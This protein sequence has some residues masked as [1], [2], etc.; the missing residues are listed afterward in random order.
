MRAARAAR[1]PI[2]PGSPVQPDGSGFQFMHR[3]PLLI[4][5]LSLAV[6]A[7][8]RA[9]A[10]S[11]PGEEARLRVG[12]LGVTP[13]ISLRNIGFDTNIFNASGEPE[14]DFTTTLGTGADSWLRVGRLYLSGKTSVDWVYFQKNSSQR[15]VN[16]SQEGRVAL[17]L[18]RLVPRAGGGIVNSRQRPNDEFDLRIHQR[19]TSMF[20]GV[21]V[22]IGVKGALDLEYKQQDFDY[23][24]GKFGDALVATA[25]NRESTAVTAAGSLELTPLTALTVRA[26]RRLD[27]FE[28][29]PSRNSNSYRVMPGVEFQPSAV[30]SGSAFVGYRK[31]ETL[32]ADTPDFSGVVAQVR[33][34][35][36]ALDMFRVIG[37]V[38]RD[39]EYSLDLEESF[40]VSTAAGVEVTQALG[41][42]W[43][44]VGRVRRHALAYR[45]TTG[46]G[47]RVDRAWQTGVGFG[48]R[49]GEQLRVGLDV[50]YVRRDSALPSRAFDGFRVGG[51]VT[52]GY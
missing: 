18:L 9:Q 32:S 39:V 8:A 38:V 27:R 2:L 20:G 6:P 34:K 7:V 40:F 47:G 49:L 37:E 24:V 29:T 12:P 14:R 50:D 28:F 35:Y 41:L 17:D 3:I 11:D 21:A 48:R 31:F 36:V 22:P 15:S 33:L 5:W 23:S 43:D 42:S 4:L 26:D 1:R 13:K 25:L 51:S 46:H 10:V 19:Q 44:V 30:V 52:Y 45:P 16:V